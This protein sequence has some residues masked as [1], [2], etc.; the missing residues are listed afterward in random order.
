[1][2]PM[3]IAIVTAPMVVMIAIS[4]V[5][6]AVSVICGALG[7]SENTL[8]AAGDTARN[9][10]YGTSYNGADRAGRSIADVRAF[11]RSATNALRPGHCRQSQESQN[12]RK[13]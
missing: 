6:I 10:A 1:M 4:V 7:H 12:R 9:A 13:F 11:S 8:H 3:V 5:M 2:A